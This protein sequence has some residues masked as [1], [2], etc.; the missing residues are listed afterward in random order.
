MQHYR[1]A[2]D[3]EIAVL[4]RRGLGNGHT[5]PAGP[6]REPP[7]R[8][9]EVDAL[10]LNDVAL[11]TLAL[12]VMPPAIFSMHLQGDE[13]HALNDN[14]KCVSADMFEHKRLHAIAGIGEPQR[15][16][17]HLSALGLSFTPHAFPD[18]HAYTT[19]ELAFG[20][21]ILTTEKDAV[22]LR[23][24]PAMTQEIWVLPVTA[25]VSEGLDQL[26]VEKLHGRAP[27]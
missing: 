22:K 4:D 21:T 2:R 12:P 27:A 18:H 5:M 20:D 25:V 10:V 8:L 7:L 6:L 13:F 3:I 1:L 23:S 16:F 15:F 19:E 26:I 17:D 14:T 9:R 11:D 24:L